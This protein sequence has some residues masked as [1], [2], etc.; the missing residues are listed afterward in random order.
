M[1]KPKKKYS[2]LT[3][4]QKSFILKKLGIRSILEIDTAILKKMKEEIKR[5]KDSRVQGRIIYKQW[6]ILMCTILASF[7]DNNE[8]GEIHQFVED[9]YSW[10]KSFLQMTGGIPSVNTIERVISLIDSD[11]LNKILFDFFKTLT[12]QTNDAV[13]LMNFDGRVNNGSGRKTT[14]LNDEISSLN[15][16]NVYSSEYMYCIYTKQISE[17]SN[18]IP[19]VEELIKGL[20]LTGIIATWDALNSQTENVK[21]V[22]AVHGDYV[23]P[24]KRNQGT[25]YQDLMDYFDEKCCEQ[26]RAGNSESAYLLQTEKSHSSIIQYEYFQTSDVDWYHKKEE[27]IGLRTIGMVKKTI[28]KE[29]T[30]HE[31]VEKNGK[32]AKEKVKKTVTT[33]EKR[34][35]ISSIEVQ[36][37]QFSE[38]IR[39]HWLVENNIH[40]HLDFTF[41]QDD[42]TTTNKKALL[43]LE[44]IH[45]FVLGVLT[46]VQSEYKKSLKNIR[47]HLS[48]NFDEYFPELLCY[49]LLH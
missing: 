36:I 17:K 21:A 31:E 10:F 43:N 5:L 9:N 3:K 30:I 12:F 8:W 35:Y 19:A 7:A 15:C 37:E 41:R 48:N 4:T 45:K 33:V 13:K 32:K 18:E 29:I 49:L 1:A 40:W 14:M 11:E 34:Y 38:A 25:F 46:R 16:L 2:L 20:D 6:D 47:K 42:N 24:I 26:I 28:T 23:I 39:N 27:W 44:I 22:I